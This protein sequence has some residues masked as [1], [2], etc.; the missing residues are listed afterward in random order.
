MQEV[1]ETVRKPRIRSLPIRRSQ[2][3][4]ID[5]QIKSFFLKIF[6]LKLLTSDRKCDNITK[7][8]MRL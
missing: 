5:A 4:R 2:M 7:R 6:P 8:G 1:D 3:E